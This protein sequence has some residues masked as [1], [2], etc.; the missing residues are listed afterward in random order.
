MAAQRKALMGERCSRSLAHLPCY[1]ETPL[2]CVLPAWHAGETPH[3]YDPADP[4][5][6]SAA[7]RIVHALAGE[8]P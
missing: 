1:A 5:D 8:W 7:P 3:R 4:G 2:Q 6:P